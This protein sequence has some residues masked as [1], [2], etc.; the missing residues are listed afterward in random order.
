MK[1]LSRKVTLHCPVCGND[2]FSS[3]DDNL[4]SLID[5][6]DDTRI[7]CSDCQTIFTKAELIEENQEAIHDNIEEIKQEAVKEIEK[8]LKKA[9]KKLR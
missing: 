1:D 9:L 2:Q 4:D 7:K 5:A 8:E 6:P 3:L